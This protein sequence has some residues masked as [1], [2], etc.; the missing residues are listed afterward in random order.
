LVSA[1]EPTAAGMLP[2]YT[3]MAAIRR[4]GKGDSA[5]V[6]AGPTT[7]SAVDDERMLLDR[8]ATWFAGQADVQMISICGGTGH[9]V[10]VLSSAL[11]AE[12]ILAAIRA[13]P[14]GYVQDRDVVFLAGAICRV[15]TGGTA[16]S[17]E[18]L[19]SGPR[20]ADPAQLA[21]RERELL[22]AYTSGMTMV[23]AA[24]R[25]GVRPSTAKTYLERIKKK[26]TGAGRPTYTK[27][28][29]AARARE[30]GLWRQST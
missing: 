8:L 13:G 9:R 4:K 20:E 18:H 30:D 19:R 11:H 6:M 12:E 7:V 29:L 5:A 25:I 3:Y 15:T 21:P 23:A 17:M 16:C 14:S 27:L 2:K 24:R 22:L 10:L 1:A 26:Y 28:D